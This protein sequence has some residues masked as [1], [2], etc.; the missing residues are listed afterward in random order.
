MANP[1][2]RVGA[3]EPMVT[4]TE[5]FRDCQEIN[6]LL[7]D[8]AAEKVVVFKRVGKMFDHLLS[9]RILG[10]AEQREEGRAIVVVS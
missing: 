9:I 6:R 1:L 8:E 3:A 7:S 5:F 10:S 4:W 2:K